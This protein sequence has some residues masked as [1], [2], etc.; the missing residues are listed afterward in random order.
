MN[1]AIITHTT[2]NGINHL[3]AMEVI[4]VIRSKFKIIKKFYSPLDVTED[5]LEDVEKIIMIVP[6]WNGSFP[7]TFKQ[8]IDN[9]GWPSFFKEKQILLI[10]TSNT[11]FGNIVGLIHLQYILEFCGAKV[12]NQKIAVPN[13]KTKFA[14]NNIIVD[15][16][17]NEWIIDFCSDC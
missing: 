14:D 9:S 10:G 17:M 16:R 11:T 5:D 7:Y 6:E 3:Q 15:N 4:N 2:D 13:V 8:M 1:L 12:Y